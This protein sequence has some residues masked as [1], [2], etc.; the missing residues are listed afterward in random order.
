MDLLGKRKFARATV[1]KANAFL[2]LLTY[3]PSISRILNLPAE[4]IV[5]NFLILLHIP[6][7]L[8][9]ILHIFFSFSKQ[10]L[11]ENIQI[12]QKSNVK[13]ITRKCLPKITPS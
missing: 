4:R 11:K 10:K 1:D 3:L 12:I 5:W 7:R 13:F 8:L 2:I 9:I 6:L